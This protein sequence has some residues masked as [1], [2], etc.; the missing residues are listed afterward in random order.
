MLFRISTFF[1]IIN[2]I[3]TLTEDKITEIFVMDYEFCKVFDAMLRRWSIGKAENIMRSDAVN[4]GCHEIQGLC[5]M[6]LII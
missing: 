3:V 4:V 1:G 2:L 5:N 6:A